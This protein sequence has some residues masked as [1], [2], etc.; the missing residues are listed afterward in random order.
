MFQTKRRVGPMAP[1]D[2]TVGL[3]SRLLLLVALGVA[4]AVGI[5]SCTSKK[6]GLVAP[7]STGKMKCGDDCLLGQACPTRTYC[8]LEGVCTADCM[9]ENDER[10]GDGEVCIVATG[11]CAPESD[12]NGEVPDDSSDVDSWSEDQDGG[13]TAMNADDVAE[14]EDAACVGLS[15]ELEA[16]PGMLMMVIDA[17]SSMDEA[18]PAT[19]G[20]SKWAVSQ[21]AL[22]AAVDTLGAATSLGMLYYPN[23]VVSAN[24]GDSTTCVNVDAL[25]PMAPLDDT[26][27]E[28]VRSTIMGGQTETC[29][30]THD[31]YQLALDSV[32]ATSSGANRYML[33]IT[34][35]QPTLSYGCMAPEG[36]DSCRS[37][38]P[39]E[40][41]PI[42]DLIAEANDEGIKTFVIGS[43]GSEV[44]A[45][46]QADA[47]PWLSYAA[48]AGGTS[49]D[50]STCSHTGEPY[51]HMDMTTEP[52]FAQALADGLGYVSSQ[53]DE[54]T[55]NIPEP[56]PGELI[57][58]DTTMLIVTLGNGEAYLIEPYNLDE[59]CTDGW[60]LTDKGHAQLCESTCNMVKSDV[61]AR[62]EVITGCT[63][64]ELIPELE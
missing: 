26:H 20:R 49:K 57:D 23:M 44:N 8:G 52:D 13:M 24:T 30:P 11:R 63:V 38:N 6:D 27:R 2:R 31:A 51:C 10:C 28:L 12:L 3:S 48:E 14:A 35:G 17:S 21:E 64:V 9:K 46:T 22:V 18:T 15:E 37:T 60:E 41:Q 36:Q 54:C 61:K 4:A 29:T 32:R 56:P 59:E 43:P 47:R 1:N 42:V 16:M 50:P 53:L 39:V 55:Y 58:P 45:G 62:V 7:C 33:L 25:V 5:A 19:N 40:E 34:D